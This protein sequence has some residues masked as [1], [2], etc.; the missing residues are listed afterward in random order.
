M[1]SFL[2]S[3][4]RDTFVGLRLAGIDGKIVHSREDALNEMKKAIQSN[5]IGI[6][7]LTEKILDM[8]KDE[9]MEYKIKSGLPLII[10]IPDRHGSARDTSAI[11]EY[12]KNSVGAEI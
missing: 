7:I 12:I 10:E 1:R 3:D 5:D 9:V 2:I 11:E 4:N 8:I 6:L